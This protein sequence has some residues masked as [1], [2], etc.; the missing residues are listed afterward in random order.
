MTKSGK[1]CVKRGVL[2]LILSK[3][4]YNCQQFLRQSKLHEDHSEFHCKIIE[5]CSK[6]P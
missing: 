5:F 6:I 3:M 2:R 4:N 1:Y